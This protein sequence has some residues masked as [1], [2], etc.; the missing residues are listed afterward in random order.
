MWVVGVGSKCVLIPAF[1]ANSV[2]SGLCSLFCPCG[3][4]LAW[5]LVWIV[6]VGLLVGRLVWVVGVGF[7][8]F[9]VTILIHVKF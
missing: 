2:N 3:L 6:G 1:V 7:R 8:S 4:L 5:A 9:G